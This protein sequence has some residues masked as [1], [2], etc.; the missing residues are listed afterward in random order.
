MNRIW[1]ILFICG[2][3][4]AGLPDAAIAQT[5]TIDPTSYAQPGERVVTIQPA[6]SY[7]GHEYTV[8]YFSAGEYDR[9]DARMFSVATSDYF[10]RQGVTGLLIT[11]DGQRVV[12]DEE[13]LRLIF[14]LY[15]AAYLLYERQPLGSLGLVDD[16]FVDDL[17]KVTSNPLFIEQQIKALFSTRWEETSEALRGIITSQSAA[18]TDISD[19]G[20]IVRQGAE[21]GSDIESVVDKTLDAARFSNSRS[22]RGVAKDIRGIFK[23]WKPVTEQATSYVELDGNRIEFFNALDVLSLSV[24]LVWL[25][26][27]QR[28]RAE[29]LNE[30]QSFATGN[31]AFDEDQRKAN[32]LVSA[33]AQDNWARRSVIVLQFVRDNAVEMGIRVTTQKLA[34]QWV[35]W[36]WKTYGKRTTGHLVAGAAS[37][38]LLGFTISNILYGLDDLYNNFQAGVRADEVRH[39]FRE[40][41]RQLQEQANRRSD[42][43][44]DGQ[45]A[46]RF[47]VAYMLE[48]LAAAQMHRVYADGVEAT[49]RQG[50]LSLINPISWFKGKEWREAAQ[51]MRSIAD[52]IEGDA[53]TEIGHPEFIDAAI[54][55][56][57]SRI[58]VIPLPSPELELSEWFPAI[59]TW[60]TELQQWAEETLAEWKA[61]L[62]T[63]WEA[64]W[65][66]QMQKLEQA[67]KELITEL[68][69]KAEIW[70][71]DFWDQQQRQLERNLEQWLDELA[72]EM[73]GGPLVL[74]VG[75]LVVAWR[76]RT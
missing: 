25:A 45:L 58:P 14:T 62:Q 52:R 51:E 76:R 24:R 68:V 13:T 75:A 21:A 5:S 72:Q 44:Y 41:R 59:S 49:V 54:V 60:T 48:S 19:F 18:P 46:A 47:R 9:Q 32:N 15:P 42:G 3:V 20:Q 73:C 28:E 37:A 2:L 34:D 22:V 33:E 66:V 27:L 69:Q 65:R 11:E 29:W 38:V 50:F 17:R 74:F 7:G 61:E 30:Y 56:A 12:D 57:S 39:R 71:R 23:S 6:L 63:R 35:K 40:G 8:H 43:P 26:G 1:R 67:T 4:I 36:S 70:W 64:F 31:A 53:E 10:Q 16:T 55:L